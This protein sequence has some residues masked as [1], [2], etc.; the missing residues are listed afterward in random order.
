M[1]TGTHRK[2]HT[3]I[4]WV[5]FFILLSVS[6]C[7]TVQAK[8]EISYIQATATPSIN[9]YK[10]AYAQPITRPT[11]TVESGSPA[12]FLVNGGNGW[13]FRL[14]DGEDPANPYSWEQIT[15]GDFSAGTWHFMCQ[16]RIDSDPEKNVG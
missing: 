16:V 14:K 2:I 7:L 3:G 8:T 9:S 5:L 13:W 10:S 12:Y 6:G 15:S 4:F 1:N 11:F